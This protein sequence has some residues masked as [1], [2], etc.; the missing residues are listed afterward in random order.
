MQGTDKVQC[1]AGFCLERVSQMLSR[2]DHTPW[3]CK[4]RNLVVIIEG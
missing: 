1:P 4:D 3:Q 2:G